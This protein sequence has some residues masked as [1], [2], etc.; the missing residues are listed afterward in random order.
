M[1]A[2]DPADGARLRWAL[3]GFGLTAALP[4]SLGLSSLVYEW[5]YRASFPH[6]PNSGWCGM[7]VLLS[8]AMIFVVGPFCGLFGAIVGWVF[9][10][11]KYP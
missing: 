1:R 7:G 9:A 6:Q 3:I 10:A 5:V 11:L 8:Y 4:V 2:H